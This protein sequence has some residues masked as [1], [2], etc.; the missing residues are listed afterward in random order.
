MSSGR[1]TAGYRRLGTGTTRGAGGVDDWPLTPCFDAF[2][3]IA[4]PPP[5]HKPNKV[6][7]AFNFFLSFSFL[8]CKLGFRI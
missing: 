4:A 3:R 6:T 8:P 1:S 2:I 5:A 7:L